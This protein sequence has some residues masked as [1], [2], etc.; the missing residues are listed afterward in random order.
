[1][2][3]ND[4]VEALNTVIAAEVDFLV[5]MG[6]RH[7]EPPATYTDD[8]R[9]EHSDRAGIRYTHDHAVAEAKR[10]ARCARDANVER[11]GL[12]K[13]GETPREGDIV[14]EDENEDSPTWTVGNINGDGTLSISGPGPCRSYGACWPEDVELVQRKMEE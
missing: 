1:M 6:W 11:T 7:V 2:V 3:S 13:T 9:W 5:A 4:M 10:E 8:V 14:C 12:Y